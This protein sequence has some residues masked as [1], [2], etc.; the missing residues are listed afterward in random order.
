MSTGRDISCFPK[1]VSLS[2][3]LVA[4]FIIAGFAIAITGLVF[5]ILTKNIEDWYIWFLFGLGIVFVLI[6]TA[7]WGWIPMK[8]KK[9]AQADFSGYINPN[10]RPVYD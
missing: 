1:M 9:P 8:E 3:V 2:A 10:P 4:V 7:I 5:L 6:G